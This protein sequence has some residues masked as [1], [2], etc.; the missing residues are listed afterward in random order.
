MPIEPSDERSAQG[1][2]ALAVLAELLAILKAYPQALQYLR[3]LKPDL[4]RQVSSLERQTRRII[5][6]VAK[7]DAESGQKP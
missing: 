1:R 3:A 6:T 5:A 7:I 2:Q 4:E